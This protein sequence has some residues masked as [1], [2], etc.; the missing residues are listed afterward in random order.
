MPAA[1]KHAEEIFSLAA[2]AAALTPRP[3]TNADSGRKSHQGIFSETP[4][5]RVSQMWVKWSGTH[6]VIEWHTSEIVLGPTIYLYE[7]ANVLEEIDNSGN[8][9]ARY[10]QGKSLDE[11]LAQLR[12]GAT[13][14]YQADGLGSITSLSNSAGALAQ[15]Y[16]YDSFGKLTAFTGTLTNPFQFTGRE[17]DSETGEYYYRARYFDQNVG[18]FISEDPI[19]FKGGDNFYRYSENS[20]TNLTDPRGLAA[21]TSVGPGPGP[22]TISLEPWAIFGLAYYDWQL[23]SLE[24]QMLQEW[25]QRQRPDA[26]PCLKNNDHCLPLL[27][28]ELEWCRLYS[29][30]EKSYWA[31]TQKAHLNYRRC[32]Q[33]L[34]PI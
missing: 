11:A 12:V 10:S 6:Q 1:A 15:T 2:G 7:G 17:S 20:P 29:K 28:A 33:G 27:Q 5:T 3:G 25:R 21:G 19:R 9:L 14:Y 4:S 23:A 24:Y 18:R 22:I 32:L 31:C 8:V 13:S 34:D 30:D 16:T 26:G